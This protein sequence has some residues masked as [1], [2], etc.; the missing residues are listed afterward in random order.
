MINIQGSRLTL[1]AVEPSDLDI[2]YI[3]ENDP[4]LWGVSGTQSPFSRYTLEQ[5]IESQQQ[6]IYSSKQLRLMVE[7]HSGETIGAIDLFEFEPRHNRAGVGIMIDSAHWHNGYAREALQLFEEYSQ[8]WLGLK[9]LWCNVGEDNEA[10]QRLFKGAG[11][12]VVGV[13]KEWNLTPNGY[14]AEILFQKL[15]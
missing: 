13:K 2:L 8:C 7:L 4:A 9:Q 10:S 1:R 5:F 15:L 6:D 11:Y 12:E 14:M 3:W